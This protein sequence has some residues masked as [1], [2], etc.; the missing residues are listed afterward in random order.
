MKNYGANRKAQGTWRRGGV[1][2]VQ[3]GGGGKVYGLSKNID[4]HAIVRESQGI[5][6]ALP[7]KEDYSLRKKKRKKLLVFCTN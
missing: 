7:L 4:V 5:L 6:V 3:T 2:G 1:H